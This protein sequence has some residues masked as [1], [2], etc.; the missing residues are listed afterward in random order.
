M[1]KLANNEPIYESYTTSAI[2]PTL[3]IVDDTNDTNKRVIKLGTGATA[4]FLYHTPPIGSTT[5]PP[6]N[7]PAFAA[8][9]DLWNNGTD[10]VYPAVKV[11]TQTFAAGTTP[12]V[13]SAA[14]DSALQTI[15]ESS[16]VA[17]AG[18]GPLLT[19]DNGFLKY[20]NK[21]LY[22]YTSPGLP[23]W[24]KAK[25]VCGPISGLLAGMY[26]FKVG[27]TPDTEIPTGSNIPAYCHD[28]KDISGNNNPFSFFGMTIPTDLNSLK[29]LLNKIRKAGTGGKLP[30]GATLEPTAK[31]GDKDAF[32][33]TSLT[34]G[35]TT[36]NNLLSQDVKELIPIG[37][38]IKLTKGDGTTQTVTIVDH[39]SLVHDKK[40]ADLGLNEVTNIEIIIPKKKS[41]TNL[42]LIIGASVG[43]AALI[44][45][46]VL[47][48]VYRRR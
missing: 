29:T 6:A 32:D 14:Y 25:V 43:G 4:E 37:T 22:Q 20:N 10:G 38:K 31:V 23:P 46:I 3:S 8:Q 15:Q 17:L 2:I 35:A 26:E 30:L 19:M 34:V 24:P 21:Y 45:L 1:Y 7:S 27:R 40:N 16:S 18:I 44:T 42:G 5:A 12:D 41:K 47:L 13:K 9:T 33:I 48:I 11:D 36:F 39:G 28:L